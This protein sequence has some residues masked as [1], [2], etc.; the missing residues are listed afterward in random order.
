[1]LHDPGSGSGEGNRGR[2]REARHDSARCR[3]RA[4]DADV[5]VGCR[6]PGELLAQLDELGQS[7]E[8]AFSESKRVIGDR[9]AVVESGRTEAAE[10]IARA[11]DE[12]EQML[13]DTEVFKVA[14]READAVLD[15]ARAESEGL[16]KEADEYVDSKLANFEITLERT[17][18]AVKRGREK[19]AGRSVF[20]GI[21]EA[22]ADELELPSHLE[23]PEHLER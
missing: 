1:M 17:I 9:E 3:G 18:E 11:R 15:R 2:A 19:L 23:R 12:R 13:S 10:I 4:V 21:T 7:L 22:A 8:D 14:K 6:E 5:G 20:E 16:V